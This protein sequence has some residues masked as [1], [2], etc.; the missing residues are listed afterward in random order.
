MSSP[1]I[2]FPAGVSNV[3]RA[4][5]VE[6]T[7][8]RPEWLR[9]LQWKTE[10][11]VDETYAELSVAS[12]I[13]DFDITVA[14]FNGEVTVFY[15]TTHVHHCWPDDH[16]N[17]MFGYGG[18]V[19]SLIDKIMSD[20]LVCVTARRDG[21]WAWSTLSSPSEIDEEVPPNQT[22]TFEVLSW[23]GKNDRKFVVRRVE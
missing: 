7:K 11:S 8:Q 23:S 3:T 5:L 18:N 14:T 22:I 16:D 2:L 13:S 21:E 9:T 19:F 6:V 15:G 4:F 10:F 1:A 17:E 20:E 12:A